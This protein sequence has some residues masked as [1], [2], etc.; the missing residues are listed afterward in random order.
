MQ[1]FCCSIYSE[2]V[3]W[4]HYCGTTGHGPNCLCAHA[5]SRMQ[6]P[7]AREVVVTVPVGI[8]P[9]LT[10]P[11]TS[12]GFEKWDTNSSRIW[13]GVQVWIN[14]QTRSGQMGA[15]RAEHQVKA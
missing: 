7:G 14:P 4:D 12:P 3:W 8:A 6:F 9:W 15:D 1:R 13:W 11:T 2:V 10:V 5:C